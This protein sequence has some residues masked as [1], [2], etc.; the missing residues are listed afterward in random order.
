MIRR[1]EIGCISRSKKKVGEV[2]TITAKKSWKIS[3]NSGMMKI[4]Q[5]EKAVKVGKA[6][7]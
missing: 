6:K 7:D 3:L 2:M 5:E 4:V 1:F